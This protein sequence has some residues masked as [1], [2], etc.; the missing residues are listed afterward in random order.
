MLNY[1]QTAHSI[2]ERSA[3]LCAEIATTLMGRQETVGTKTR[4]LDNDT[5]AYFTLEEV[6]TANV[7]SFWFSPSPEMNNL[8]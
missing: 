1:N 5:L 2:T 4:R 3:R 8:D 7:H 6:I